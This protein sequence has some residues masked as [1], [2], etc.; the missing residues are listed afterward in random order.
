M[1]IETTNR[2]YLSVCLIP[3]LESILFSHSP[4]HVQLLFLE[5]QDEY[6]DDLH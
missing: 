4:L 6:M 3:S 2:S 1:F 5:N